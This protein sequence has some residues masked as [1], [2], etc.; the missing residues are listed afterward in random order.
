MS[1]SL[2]VGGDLILEVGSSDRV[3]LVLYEGGRMVWDVL[4]DDGLLFGR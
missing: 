3:T 1:D 2:F 4:R